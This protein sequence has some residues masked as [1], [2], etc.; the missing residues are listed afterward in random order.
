[1]DMA[2]ERKYQA[3]SMITLILNS[4]VT[5]H[6]S[7]PEQQPE[8]IGVQNMVSAVL[9]SYRG[10]DTMGVFGG[11]YLSPG[12]GYAGIVVAM[13]AR[14]SPLGVI[15]SAL[16]IAAVFV[17]ADTMSRAIGVSS[18]LADLVVATSLLTVLVGG[19]V[20]RYRLVRVRPE[21]A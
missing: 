8:E 11:P 2:V 17:G 6:W 19:F 1:M 9:A 16:F 3:A 20:A 21:R 14:L 12:F 18:Y 13:L 4:V 15:A 5:G 10:Y 7:P